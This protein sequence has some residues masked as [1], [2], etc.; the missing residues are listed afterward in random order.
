YSFNSAV[1]TFYAP[2]DLS[3]VNG[4]HQQCIHASSLWR[5]GS[6]HYDCV[7]VE[8]DPTLPGFQGIFVAQVL[9]FFSFHYQNVYYPCALVQ[10][11]TP[12]ESGPYAKIGMW[13]VEHE[14]D[15]FDNHLVNIIHLD[16][17]L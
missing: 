11:F 2:S 1:A 7:F 14:Y 6:S 9:L 16:S 12:I 3:G 15:E 4:M 10:W 5:N 8:K 17:I 13:I